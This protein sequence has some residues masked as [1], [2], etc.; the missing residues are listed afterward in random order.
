MA[1]KKKDKKEKVKRGKKVRASN[2]YKLIHWGIFIALPFIVAFLL[3]QYFVTYPIINEIEQWQLAPF[4]LPIALTVL[5]VLLGILVPYKIIN[6]SVKKGG[7]FF[8][9]R[10]YVKLANYLYDNGY[11]VKKATN[12]TNNNKEKVKFPPIYYYQSEDF[13]YFRFRTGNMF[14]DKF[15]KMGEHLEG[16]FLADLV[17]VDHTQDY[18]NYKLLVNVEGKRLDFEKTKIEDGKLTFMRGVVWDFEG[19]PHMLITG[20]TGGGKTFFIYTLI[21]LLASVGRVHLAD[22][23]NSDLTYLNNFK[24]FKGAVASSTDEIMAQMKLAVELMEKRYKYM[25]EHPDRKM[26]E[27]YRYYGMKP[28]FFIIDEWGAFISTLRGTGEAKL[29]ELISPLVL[30]ARQAGVFLIIATQKA[31]TEVLKSMIRDNLMCKVS[32]GILSET[33]YDMTFGDAS[34]RKLFVNKQSK[35]GRGYIDVVRP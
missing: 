9:K 35:V 4:I 7:Y 5:C 10:K 14:H 13:D 6:K 15:Q 32:L 3:V 12:T 33:G 30:K 19:Q 8:K 16:V 29:Y 22:P 1:R 34:K 11:V 23:K 17:G 26:G 31:S 24:A 27:N 25:N 21:A 28:E 2:R 20:G 18:I